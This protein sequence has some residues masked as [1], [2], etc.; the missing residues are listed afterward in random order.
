MRAPA[1]SASTRRAETPR[2]PASPERSPA[3]RRWDSE[4]AGTGGRSVLGVAAT[5]VGA[6]WLDGQIALGGQLSVGLEHD[7]A[8]DPELC[9]ERPGRG[10]PRSRAASRPLAHLTRA[11]AARAARAGSRPS[12]GRAP[13]EGRAR[14]KLALSAPPQLDLNTEPVAAYGSRSQAKRD[15]TGGRSAGDHGRRGR[16]GRSDRRHLLR[17]A[18]RRQCDCSR[19]TPSS[20][21]GPAAWTGRTRRT[22]ARTRCC[23]AV[24]SGAGWASAACSRPTRGRRCR[25]CAFAGSDDIRRVPAV[26]AAVA[27]LRLRGRTAPVDL[28]FRTW[29]TDQRRRRAA[30]AL[31]RSAGILTYHHDPG[32]LSAA[33]LWEPLVRGLLSAPPTARYPIGGWSADHRAAAR[34]RARSARR[35]DRD[36]R[37]RRR[38]CRRRR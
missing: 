12:R 10:Q 9:G 36:R 23:R 32:E 34:P 37:P 27:A 33:F 20:A 18:G 5:R 24:R 4:P 15:R 13:A 26:G 7:A 3:R 30:E 31:S 16:P 8:R 14:P 6:P 19:P 21:D 29:A 25:A 1:A 17:R 11:A 22:W 2:G 38:C 35:A 28:D